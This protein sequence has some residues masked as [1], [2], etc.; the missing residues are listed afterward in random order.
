MIHC[1]Q[2]TKSVI[3][4]TPNYFYR[5]GTTWLWVR[6]GMS[7]EWESECERDCERESERE[8]RRRM[9]ASTARGNK[10]R[11]GIGSSKASAAPVKS[12]NHQA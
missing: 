3:P 2:N 8:R 11:W 1:Q 6:I 7:S 12:G 5:T 10:Q 9:S 4:L